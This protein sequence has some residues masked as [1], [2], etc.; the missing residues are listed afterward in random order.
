MPFGRMDR[1]EV[2]EILQSQSL[3]QISMVVMY[4]VADRLEKNGVPPISMDPG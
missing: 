1:A 2:Y 4:F 3:S